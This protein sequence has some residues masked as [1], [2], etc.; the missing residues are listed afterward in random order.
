MAD[1]SDPKEKK[2]FT[3]MSELGEAFMAIKQEMDSTEEFLDGVAKLIVKA[4][5][6]LLAY[7]ETDIYKDF[8]ELAIF[9]MKEGNGQNS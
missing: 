5:D 3:A 4:K 8:L 1:I 2:L 7:T 6:V 9:M